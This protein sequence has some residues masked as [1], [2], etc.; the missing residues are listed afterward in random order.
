MASR[1]PDFEPGDGTLSYYL[2]WVAG[3][4]VVGFLVGVVA[5]LNP[6]GTAIAGVGVLLLGNGALLVPEWW[7]AR[8][9]ERQSVVS[10]R[11]GGGAAEVAGETRSAGETVTAPYSGEECLAYTVS[12]EDYEYVNRP[13]GGGSYEWQ[14][15]YWDTEQ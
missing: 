10:L 3:G 6:F 15:R 1:Q 2:R 4:L 9:I 11:G 14:G 7:Q 12:V 5:G 8:S 13:S